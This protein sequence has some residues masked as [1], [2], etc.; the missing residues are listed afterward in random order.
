MD[1]KPSVLIVDDEPIMVG[2]V[3]D[4]LVPRGYTVFEATDGNMGL[5]VFKEKRPD[6]VILDIK[7]PGI[8]GV[9]LKNLIREIDCNVRIIMT[10]GH[11]ETIES[12]MNSGEIFLKKPFH[13]KELITA[14]EIEIE[15]LKRD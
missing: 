7:M 15:E 3:R 12:C 6:I 10:S 5:E 11:V 9:K 14:L 4:F 1:K 2:I 8:D 13:I